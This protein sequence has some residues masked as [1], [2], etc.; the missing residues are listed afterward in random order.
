MSVKVI[1]S[2]EI[3]G[4]FVIVD[5]SNKVIDD[6]Q[7]YGYKSFMSAKKAMNYKYGGGK[8]KSANRSAEYKG[9]VKKY[10]GINKFIE[11]LYLSSYKELSRGEIKELDFIKEVEEK[12]GV[13]L[14]VSQ[15]RGIENLK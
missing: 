15:I 11:D 12:Y 9:I 2:K 8:E 3:A 13:K 10:A 6:A 14:T 7:G 1:D 4:R 5:D